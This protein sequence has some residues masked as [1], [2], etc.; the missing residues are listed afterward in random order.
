MHASNST[1]NSRREGDTCSLQVNRSA[2]WPAQQCECLSFHNA[3]MRSLPDAD[4]TARI[5]RKFSGDIGRS[6]TGTHLSRTAHAARM[7]NDLTRCAHVPAPFGYGSIGNQQCDMQMEEQRPTWRQRNKSQSEMKT[8]ALAVV[9]RSPCR[10][11]F[12]GIEILS[13]P[14]R[15]AVRGSS[16]FGC[17]HTVY[18]LY[19]PPC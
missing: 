3:R 8:T 15:D 12:R 2:L 6:V 19:R 4:L 16:R 1:R 11:Y 14:H 17:P 13:I 9:F 10:D 18:F 5:L 7:V